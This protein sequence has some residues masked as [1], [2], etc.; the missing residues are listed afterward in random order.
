MDTE[1]HAVAS[2]DYKIAI[3]RRVQRGRGM[4][5]VTFTGYGE[6]SLRPWLVS[7]YIYISID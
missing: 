2:L 4:A 5:H 7:I 3:L 1:E 6:M